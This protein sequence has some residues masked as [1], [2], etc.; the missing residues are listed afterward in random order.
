MKIYLLP[1]LIL[2]SR[3][4]QR[5]CGCLMFLPSFKIFSGAFAM[6]DSWM[7]ATKHHLKMLICKQSLL[8]QWTPLMA[9]EMSSSW[10]MIYLALPTHPLKFSP[11]LFSLFLSVDPSI[12]PCFLSV[13]QPPYS[14]LARFWFMK[15]RAGP[16]LE[17][18]TWFIVTDKSDGIVVIVCGLLYN[19]SKMKGGGGRKWSAPSRGGR[20]T[21]PVTGKG[22]GGKGEKGKGS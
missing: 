6:F 8:R 7:M 18:E 22:C 17:I 3:I 19:A 4:R 13:S 21:H 9:V 2:S 10:S 5:T 11:Y 14:L 1:I 20:V 15:M 12:H 16:S